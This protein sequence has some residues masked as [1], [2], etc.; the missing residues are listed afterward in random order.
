MLSH[1]GCNLCYVVVA[2]HENNDHN[3]HKQ[4]LITILHADMLH[5]DITISNME[6]ESS[7]LDIYNRFFI[8]VQ[9]KTCC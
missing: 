6:E 2:T 5:P 8:F 4:T 7:C 9:E 1:V 3:N